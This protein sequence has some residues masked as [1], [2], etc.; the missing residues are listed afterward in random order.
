MGL[1]KGPH[2]SQ[3]RRRAFINPFARPWEDRQGV[4]T[5]ISQK[6][7]FG[8]RDNDK[9]PLLRWFLETRIRFRVTFTLPPFENS[10]SDITRLRSMPGN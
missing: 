2:T 8:E 4:V 5:G 3:R 1:C 9:F 10:Q 7:V 6:R